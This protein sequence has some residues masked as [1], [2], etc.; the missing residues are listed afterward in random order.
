MLH[1]MLVSRASQLCSPV[2]GRSLGVI[3]CRQGNNSIVL[4]SGPGQLSPLQT[5][6]YPLDRMYI[7]P[8]TSSLPIY[9]SVQ[10]TK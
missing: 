3:S 6:L 7:L 10:V 4:I 9:V 2:S 1:L 8:G 5:V